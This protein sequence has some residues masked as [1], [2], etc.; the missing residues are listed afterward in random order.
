MQ[1]EITA[2]LRQARA[3]LAVSF[4]LQGITFA[5][6]V[7]CIPEIQKQYG[8]S[9]S[10]LPVFLAAVPILA[11]VGSI[12]SEQLVKRTSARAVLRVVQPAVCLTLAGV[13]LGDAL[14]QLGLA[15]GAFGLLVGALDASMNML[16]V[17]LQHRYGRSIMLGFHAAFSLGGIVGAAIAGI[18]AHYDLG[19]TT[20]FGG[21]AGVLIPLALLAGT[22]FAGR[23][24]LG[25]AVREAAEAAARSIPW[26]PLLPL[27]LAM[28]VAY[29]ADASV[30]N[31]SVKY[32]TDGLHSPEDVAKLSYLGYMVAMLLGR[33]LGDRGVQRWG[34]V[35]VV[36]TGAAVAALGF[37]IAAAAPAPWAG[38]AGFTVLGLGICAIIPQVF[39][40]GGRL[41]PQDSD[42]AVARLN[43]FNYV[44]FLVGSP[45]VGAVADA[46]SYR[47]A[48]L[49]PMLLV[50][51]I[52]PLGAHFAP[53]P[54]AAARPLRESAPAETS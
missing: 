52:L 41:F 1:Q 20:L 35:P 4:L 47:L 49:A 36:R 53:A 37:A 43:L 18:G 6:L 51:G 8:L 11:G 14:W 42:A 12:G 27:C 31:Y 3:A 32:L 5:L 28:A 7:T 46:S 45:L 2:R 40:A 30:S 23:A 15:L 26:K 21:A 9:D 19:L 50:L 29:I 13:G 10:L 22:R 17:G 25:D 48:L 24:E 33:T 16:G 38:I 39:A 44:G 54:T 34:A